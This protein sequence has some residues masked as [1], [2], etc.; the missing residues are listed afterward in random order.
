M[1]D[2]I[3]KY[4]NSKEITDSKVTARAVRI[5]NKDA[6]IISDPV[7]R[8]I[9]FGSLNSDKGE[10]EQIIE[11]QIYDESGNKIESVYSENKIDWTIQ[12]AAGSATVG[13]NLVLK[14]GSDLRINGYDY[15]AFKLVYNVF[16]EFII[17]L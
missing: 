8:P 17:K 1:A 7:K 10:I 5:S 16:E 12:K 2:D 3:N 9:S 13:N 11:L 15:G 14:P 4:G 6:N